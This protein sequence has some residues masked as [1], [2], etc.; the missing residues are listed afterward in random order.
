MGKKIKGYLTKYALTGGI[1]EISG[2]IDGKYINYRQEGGPS[3]GFLAVVGKEFFAD[4]DLALADVKKRAKAKIA[5]LQKQIDK[6]K[7][8]VAEPKFRGKA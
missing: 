4:R 5:S 7:K 8:L 2:E 1:E 6:M 3:Y